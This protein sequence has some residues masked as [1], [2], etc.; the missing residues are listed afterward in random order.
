MYKGAI[1]LHNEFKYYIDLYYP[2]EIKDK[3]IYFNDIFNNFLGLSKYPDGNF[4][5]IAPIVKAYIENDSVITGELYRITFRS[6]Y[7]TI[8]EHEFMLNKTFNNKLLDLFY[9][10]FNYKDICQPDDYYIKLKLFI[11]MFFG[12]GLNARQCSD[13]IRKSRNILNY[14]VNVFENNEIDVL[15]IDTDEI[16]VK[17]TDNGDILKVL[18]DVKSAIK[19]NK[20]MVETIDTMIFTRLK[21]VIYRVDK[22]VIHHLL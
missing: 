1:E 17:V 16:I 5:G 10:I 2:A 13:I 6:F 7:P 8:M 15:Y 11:N 22:P 12:Y 18:N 20:I 19:Y 4:I 9:I 3:K 14:Y 21:K